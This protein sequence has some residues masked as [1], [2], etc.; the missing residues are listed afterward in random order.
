MRGGRTLASPAQA[1]LRGATPLTTRA[2]SRE[3]LAKKAPGGVTPDEVRPRLCQVGERLRDPASATG[4]DA[5]AGAQ[6]GRTTVAATSI[7]CGGRARSETPMVLL[8]GPWVPKYRR[9]RPRQPGSGSCR[10]SLASPAAIGSADPPALYR[11]TSCVPAS[12]RQ[13]QN[14][15]VSYPRRLEI[16]PSRATQNNLF[17]GTFSKPSDGLEPSTPS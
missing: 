6:P 13:F 9:G 14:V 1:D 3:P 8:A 2:E 11:E 17:A 4:R 5:G 12:G 7:S 15:P 16:S 10:D